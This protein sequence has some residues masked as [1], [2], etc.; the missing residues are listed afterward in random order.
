[1]KRIKFSCKSILLRK[2][3]F[4]GAVVSLSFLPAI[5]AQEASNSA[6]ASHAASVTDHDSKIPPG[7]I[8]PIVLRTSIAVRKSK[9]G[10]PIRGQIA[11]GVPLSNG[12][13]IPKGSEVEG[14]IVEVEQGWTAY[15]PKVALQFDRIKFQGQTVRLVTNVRAIAGLMEVE[16]AGVPTEAPSEGTPF[17]W[18]DKSQIGGDSVYGLDGPVTSG[19][20]SSKVVGKSVNDGVLAHVSAKSGTKCRGAVAGNNDL[21]AVWVFSSDGCGV[22]GIEH[23]K[24]VHAGRTEPKGTIVL[25][26]ETANLKLRDGDGLLLRVD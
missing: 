2:C 15:G 3:L 10:D 8:L 18:L 17:N 12:L 1:M 16:E 23:L 19:E 13:K 20:D 21:Q 22:Y 24:I 9:P 6:Q 14:R 5:N 4:L 7:T 25:M 11:Q 26:S